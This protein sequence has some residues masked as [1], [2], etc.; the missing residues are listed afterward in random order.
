M[1]PI[2]LNLKNFLSYGENVPPLDFTQFHVACLSG[3]N[4]QGKSALLDAITWSVWGE[5]RKASQ[6]RKAD[7]SL[8]RMGQEDMQ[9]E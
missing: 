9:V 3:H 8:L 1:I 7:Y 5:G 4:G 2:K 6:E